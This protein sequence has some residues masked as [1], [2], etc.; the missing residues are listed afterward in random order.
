MPPYAL[1]LSAA[2]PALIVIGSYVSTN[3]VVKIISF[4]AL[5]IYIAFQMV[6]LAALRARLKG[7]VPSGKYQLGAWGIPVNVA[8]LV[9][10]V[11]A[12]INMCWPRTPDAAWYDNWL[13]LLS[14]VVVIGLGLLYML[15]HPAADRSDAPYDD[16]IPK[17]AASR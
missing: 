7:W 8:A 17:A 6:V 16:A 14:A 4:A 15:I 3:A 5:G 1:L 9:Y 10:G 13:V 12:M 11:I 2:I